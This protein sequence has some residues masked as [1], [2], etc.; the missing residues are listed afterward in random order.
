MAGEDLSHSDT[1]FRAF[2]TRI[3][4]LKWDID[5]AKDTPI[6]RRVLE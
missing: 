2:R 1:D 3:E 4:D 6:K 5:K